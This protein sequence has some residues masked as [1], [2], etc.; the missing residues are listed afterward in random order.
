MFVDGPAT[1]TEL[2][3]QSVRRLEMLGPFGT[4]HPRPRFLTSNVRTVGYPTTDARGQDLK[5]RVVA[6][7]QM[8]P[9]RLLRGAARFEELRS[10]RGPWTLL[11]SPRLSSRGEEGPVILEVHEMMPAE[12]DNQ[13][14]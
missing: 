10:S 7:G 4:G 9:A 2:D 3:P 5:L 14:K 11:H 13:G 1:L 12:A 6:D 8:L